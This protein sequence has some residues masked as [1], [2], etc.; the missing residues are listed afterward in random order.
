MCEYK[1]NELN[2]IKRVRRASI[3]CRLASEAY[4]FIQHP[5]LT[6]SRTPSKIVQ[7]II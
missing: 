4:A 2:Q 3:P 5:L 7:K 6:G 1:F